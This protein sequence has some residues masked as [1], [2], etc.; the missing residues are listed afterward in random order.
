MKNLDWII[1]ALDRVL[2]IAC[3]LIVVAFACLL[4]GQV[5]LR[6]AWD[7][8]LFWVEE[9]CRFLLVYLTFLGS[10]L[11]WGRRDHIAIDFVLDV[12][13]GRIRKAMIVMVDL[14]LLGFFIWAVYAGW[15]YA[16]ASMS[17]ISISLGVPNG[18]AY[19]CAPI[20][21]AIMAVQTIVFLIRGDRDLA[22]PTVPVREV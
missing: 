10:A 4:A 17:R 7:A 19:A 20:A 16:S 1:L 22:Q 14:L 6:Y 21:F 8:P 9:L 15:V 13:G 3:T 5:A 2:C 11:A 18:Y 12:V